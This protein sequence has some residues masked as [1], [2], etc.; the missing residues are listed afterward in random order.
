MTEQRNSG[1][2]PDMQDWEAQVN[3]LLDGELSDAEAEE[4]KSAAEQDQALARAIIEAYQ[5]Q[6][7]LASIPQERA[8]ASL[9]KKLRGWR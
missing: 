9:R 7:M 5:L 3:D 2:R 1:G 8:P 4:L 6:R